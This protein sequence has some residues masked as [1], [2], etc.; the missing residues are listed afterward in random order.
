MK[1]LVDGRRVAEVY[2]EA[3]KSRFRYM[4]DLAERALA[5]VG[6][7]AL[8]W[9][10]GEESNSITVI[11]KHLSG[12]MLSR[13]TDFLTSDGEKPGRD[14]DAEFVE[15]RL[16]RQELMERWE[17]G[18]QAL[19]AALDAL[20]PDDLLRTVS[21]RGEP[22]TVIDAIERQMFHY[23]YHVGQIIYLAK[24]RAG[25]RWRSLTIPRRR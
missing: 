6:D 11:I 17:R 15:E 10:P 12:N 7:D 16:P 1:D 18:W 25:E 3:V 5:Q 21:I 2:L 23:A 4:K 19:F 22:H 14:R 13:W 20:G 8:T 9:S 24:A